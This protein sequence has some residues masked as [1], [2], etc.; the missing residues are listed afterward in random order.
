MDDE[1][2][3]SLFDAIDMFTVSG[4]CVTFL[5]QHY[6]LSDEENPAPEPEAE[7]EPPIVDSL[8]EKP[9]SEAD[10]FGANGF[11][12]SASSSASLPSLLSILFICLAMFALFLLT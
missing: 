10:V 6:S 5:T 7:L 12:S 8:I 4:G 9:I 1:E 2:S 11:V 3:K